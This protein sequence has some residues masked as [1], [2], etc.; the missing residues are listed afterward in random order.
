LARSLTIPFG[1]LPNLRRSVGHSDLPAI[2]RSI[3][4]A[5]EKP[6]SHLPSI[7][8]PP[9][10]SLIARRLGMRTQQSAIGGTNGWIRGS[11]DSRARRGGRDRAPTCLSKS[12]WHACSL[13]WRSAASR[14]ELQRSNDPLFRRTWVTPIKLGRASAPNRCAAASRS[15]LWEAR[16]GSRPFL[17]P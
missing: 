9:S 7:L 3:T 17:A 8:T 16:P 5:V 15:R 4:L 1:M 6:Q 10:R 13:V 2:S 12:T 11:P 14:Q